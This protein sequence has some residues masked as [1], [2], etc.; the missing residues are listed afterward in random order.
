[1]KRFVSTLLAITLV[2]LTCVAGLASAKQI[3]E[4]DAPATLIKASKFLEERPLDKEAKNIRGWAVSWVIETDKVTVGICA[5]L[6]G[7]IEEKYK[8]SSEIIAQ[9]TIGMAAFKLANPDRAKD[10]DAAQLAGVESALKSYEVIVN[11]KPKNRNAFMDELLA[12]RANGTL[13][14]YVLENNCKAKK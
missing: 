12:K 9:Y 5:I 1:M 8:Y 11:E 10:E 14:A 3:D 4:K 13:A 2:S 6:L 7:G